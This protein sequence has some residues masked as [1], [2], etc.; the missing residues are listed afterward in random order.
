MTRSPAGAVVT[1][2]GRGLGRQIARLL[3]ARGHQVLVTDVDPASAQATADELG[4]RATA[5]AVD[6]RDHA[7]VEAARDAIVARAGRLDV[8]VNNAG[9]LVT[10]PAWEQDAATRRLMIEVNSLG[11]INGTVAA[12]G[13]MRGTGGGHVVNI[14]SLAGLTAVAGEAVYAASKH[15][16]IGFSLSTM[17]DLKVAGVRDID[18]SCVCPDGIWTPMLH[19]KLNDPG[20]AL[21]FSGKLLQPEEVV[22][23]VGKV[24]DKPR[25]VTT[26]PGWRGLVARL[27]DMA[28]GFGLAVVSLVVAQGR[29]TQKRLLARGGPRRSEPS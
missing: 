9:V 6:V 4:D 17:A 3:V 12:I 10:G 13:A 14:V 7:Q 29:R 18:I 26:L 15:A 19:D 23:A 21:S 1:G 2:A 20:C 27:A 28:P 24:L 5:L 16:A 25:P 8:W 22:K 11:T